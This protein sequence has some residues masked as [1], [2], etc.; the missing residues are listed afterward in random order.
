MNG[1][2]FTAWVERLL[3]PTLVP[4]DIV[5]LDNLI[6]ADAVTCGVSD[7]SIPPVPGTAER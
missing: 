1:A 7:V 3:V 4:G 2:A 6:D 5:V